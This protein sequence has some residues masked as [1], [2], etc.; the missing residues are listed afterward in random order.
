LSINIA[1]DR[2]NGL[3]NLIIIFLVYDG[4]GNVWVD[5]LIDVWVHSEI[6]EMLNWKGNVIRVAWRHLS[7]S[8]M[9]TFIIDS[10]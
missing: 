1:K 10:K 8:P 9:S 7:V 3:N 4:F 5:S 6:T 2:S